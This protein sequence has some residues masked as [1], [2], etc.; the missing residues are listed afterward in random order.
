[1]LRPSAL[2][3]TCLSTTLCC[4]VL[5]LAAGCSDKEPMPADSGAADQ[6]LDRARPD[7][8]LDA[9]P[10]MTP[11]APLSDAS[12]AGDAARPCYSGPAG[13][14]GVGLCAAGL[15]LCAGG[16]WSACAGQVV[17]ATETCDNKDNDCDGKVDQALTQACYTGDAKTRGVGQCKDGSQ[18][19]AAGKWSACVGQLL[20]GTEVCDNKDNDCDGKIDQALTQ[21]CYTGAPITKKV[22]P[23]KGGTQ[24]CGG[25]LWSA[26]SG[27]VLPA[28]E[29]CDN[30]DNDCDGKA[31]QMQAACYTGPAGTLG[32]GLCV[33]G[34]QSCAQGV[35]G[36]C[37]GQVTPAGEVCDN[38]DNDCNG[39]ID[40]ALTKTCYTG[41]AKTKG[42]G[43]CKAGTETCAAGKW[44][45]CTAQVLPTNE[46]CDKADNDC[47]G[48]ADEDYVCAA[49]S[50]LAGV[51]LAFQDGPVKQARFYFPMDLAMDPSG[52]VIVLDTYSNRI[53]KIAA[54]QVT[55]IAGGLY[56]KAGFVDGPAASARFN[57][58]WGLA[59]GPAGQI[60]VADYQG[61]RL[62]V[63]AN[64]QV[65]T[66][67][68][69]GRVGLKDGAAKDAQFANPICVAAGAGKTIY[70]TDYGNN[71]VR[72]LT[73]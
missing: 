32:Q 42:V 6:R 23:C 37:A 15:Q 51:G 3:L 58:P 17:P 73:W 70:I 2:L 9:A 47:D 62:R 65:S 4:A 14:K 50:T 71:R 72:K 52:A 22:G 33:A 18:A 66:L 20:P 38:K 10:D 41:D 5:C 31:D 45:A 27:Q 16:S 46:V 64:G 36:G 54:G 57:G 56:G 19:C 30:V 7:A 29:T 55:T 68:G 11:D 28:A 26:C 24:T 40:D 25:G 43:L 44:S 63:V 49:V 48:E 67:A 69:D 61:G 53:R 1:M 35:W 39:K 8:A 21:S 59:V 12:C 34:K 60:F 13:T